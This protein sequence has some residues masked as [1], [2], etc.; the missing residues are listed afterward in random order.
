M[1]N[2]A[3]F[4]NTTFPLHNVSQL[5]QPNYHVSQVFKVKF[6]QYQFNS[7]IISGHWRSCLVWSGWSVLI[8]LVCLFW[9]VWFVLVGLVWLVWPGWFGLD[10]LVWLVWS[11]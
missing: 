9:S 6:T 5:C 2:H 7:E 11:G 4:Y 1:S 10:G 3:K 8:V